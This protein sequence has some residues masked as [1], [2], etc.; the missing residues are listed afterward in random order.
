MHK[1]RVRLEAGHSLKSS[2]NHLFYRDLRDDIMLPS[3]GYVVKLEQVL[4]HLFVLFFLSIFVL[5]DELFMWF[6]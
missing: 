6:L 3:R 2:I 4:I 5:V 1:I